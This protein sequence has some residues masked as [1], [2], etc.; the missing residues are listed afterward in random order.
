M[1]LTAPSALTLTLAVPVSAAA[2][3]V[4][5]Y[6]VADFLLGPEEVAQYQESW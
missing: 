4:D 3:N 5:E 1:K 2:Q 6:D